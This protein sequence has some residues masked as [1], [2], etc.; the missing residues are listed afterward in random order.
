M[1][2]AARW[3]SILLTLGDTAFFDIIRNYLGEVKTP[4]NKHE[5]IGRLESFLLNGENQG[6]IVSLVDESERKILEAVDILDDPGHEALF[7]Y[8]HGEF[9][10][11][12]LHHRLLNLEDRL[13]IYR[14]PDEKSI[15]LNPILAPA[16][17]ATILRRERVF[18]GFTVNSEDTGR[19]VEEIPWFSDAVVL[20]LVSYLLSATEIFR[21][22]GTLRKK[23]EDELAA[24]F[25][26]LMRE[27]PGI[28]RR[29]D[30]LV[31]A[32]LSLGALVRTDSGLVPAIDQLNRLGTMSAKDRHELYW[33]S[34]IFR[35]SALAADHLIYLQALEQSIPEGS[36]YPP[37][38]VE[39]LC[40][41][42]Y[43]RVMRR[44]LPKEFG[45]A[46]P[47]FGSLSS[48][49]PAAEEAGDGRARQ[50][51]FRRLVAGLRRLGFLC[52]TESGDYALNPHLATVHADEGPPGEPALIVQPTFAVTI[53]PWLPLS[54]GI[55][56]AC[57]SEIR[58]F[59]LYPQYELTKTSFGRALSQGY[60]PEEL[61]FTL[62]A[63][64]GKSLP[65][66]VAFSLTTWAGEFASIALYEGV[67]L[68]ADETRR[69][70]VE[71][72]ER[73]RPF[74][75]RTL[76][77]GVY[78]L[79]PRERSQWE[80]VLEAEGIEMLPRSPAATL[81]GVP[82]V[83]LPSRVLVASSGAPPRSIPR[84]FELFAGDEPPDDPVED[85]QDPENIEQT[86]FSTLD[87]LDTSRDKREEIAERI[88]RKLIVNPD[89]INPHITRGERIEAK[90][91]DYTGK[92][93]L[94]EQAL[95]DQRGEERRG[96]Y[97][98]I[99][100]RTSRGTPSRLLV[101]P[102]ELLRT[103]NQLVLLANGIP[104]EQEVRIPVS[105]MVLVRKMKGTLFG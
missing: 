91:L 35:D 52:E 12:D 19:I 75:R 10:Y 7:A 27:T 57:A 86:L 56:I 20:S 14:D 26:D 96:A 66:N 84:N 60:E 97:L 104:E 62:E 59:D 2:T 67:V 50:E 22:D 63:L 43:L 80:V 40:S 28:S 3:R 34:A 95:K 47:S 6:R 33:L 17:H 53:K 94:I 46:E 81:S 37:R 73:L 98:E 76:A 102:I 16:L 11:V 101:R 38:I 71:H 54:T 90:G 82:D 55:S 41:V 23:S 68:V 100:R 93:R 1:R 31:G 83:R 24:V 61:R 48:L 85:L 64:S 105:K 30:V 32:L 15:C 51:G 21:A 45:G 78:L 69:F 9:S 74:I 77:A 13:L 29:L 36:A 18:P 39:K 8:L 44:D 79:D 65:Q 70:L 25:P 87:A 89:Q 58:R 88:R 49:P 99:V 5:L 72:S 103:G 4:F 42:I 92:I